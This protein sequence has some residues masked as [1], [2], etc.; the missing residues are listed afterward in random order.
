MIRKIALALRVLCIAAALLC[1]AQASRAADFGR[2][3]A[4]TYQL[5]NVVEDGSKVSVEVTVTLH[6]PGSSDVKG[7]IVAIMSAQ[8]NPTLLGSFH[9]INLLT[10]GGHV[11]II[12]TFSIPASEYASW[13]RGHAP[14]FEFL[15]P[16]GDS[17]IAAGIQSHQ[18]TPTVT[19][20]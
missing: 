12:H 6:N 11:T 14:T 17:A 3:F 2:A 20:N 5:S 8:P 4:A 7:G 19:S 13:Q 15:I 18:T 1:M 9:A 10:H 16:S